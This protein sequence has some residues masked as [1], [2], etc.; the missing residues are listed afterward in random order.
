MD[1][2]VETVDSGSIWQGRKR[3]GKDSK[4][5]VAVEAHTLTNWKCKDKPPVPPTVTDKFV[6]VKNVT[7]LE[8]KPCIEDEVNLR[9]MQDDTENEPIDLD[10]SV[11]SNL[12]D[13]MFVEIKW[14]KTPVGVKTLTTSEK[15]KKYDR[16]SSNF[17]IFTLLEEEPCMKDEET[18][19]ENPDTETVLDPVVVEAPTTENKIQTMHNSVGVEAQTLTLHRNSVEETMVKKVTLLEE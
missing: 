15:L 6:D 17:N 11:Y 10:K 1:L 3:K 13:G 9:E 19:T 4:K 5:P 2:I 7:L 8:D 16:R 14:K 18:S 12:R